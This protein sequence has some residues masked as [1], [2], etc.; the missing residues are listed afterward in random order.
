M[1]SEEHDDGM[2]AAQTCSRCGKVVEEG[3]FYL[4]DSSVVCISCAVS[5][6]LLSQTLL[7]DQA[8]KEAVR[9]AAAL[10]AV[11]GEKVAARLEELAR[12]LAVTMLERAERTLEAALPVSSQGGAAVAE[13]ERLVKLARDLDVLADKVLVRR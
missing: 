10:P 5:G 3:R 1:R 13:A 2:A 11:S 8:H 12:K 7:H 6:P 9:S 4:K